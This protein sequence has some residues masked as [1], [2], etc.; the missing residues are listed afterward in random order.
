MSSDDW[1]LKVAFIR[2]DFPPPERDTAQTVAAA[3]G[4][5]MGP[6][7]LQLRPE[8]TMGEI[9]S[10]STSDGFDTVELLVALEEEFL[11][12]EMVDEFA[13][14]FEQ[15]TFREFVEY[16]SRSVQAW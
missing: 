15:R 6:A 3:F 1:E 10:W 7:I 9:M 8:H 11:G 5:V 2:L 12:R 13:A 16:L 4:E 14:R